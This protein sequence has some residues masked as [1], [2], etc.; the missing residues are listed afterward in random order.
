MLV[1]LQSARRKEQIVV[2]GVLFRIKMNDLEK[3]YG[4]IFLRNK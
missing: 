3:F 2:K 1:C 4:I